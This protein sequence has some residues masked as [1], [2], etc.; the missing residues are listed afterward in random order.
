[1]FFSSAFLT[2]GQTLLWYPDYHR[3]EMVFSWSILRFEVLE[4]FDSFMT[5]GL[6]VERSPDLGYSFIQRSK[7]FCFCFTGEKC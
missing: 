5:E 2:V 7:M 4:C 6:N 3:V 1:M